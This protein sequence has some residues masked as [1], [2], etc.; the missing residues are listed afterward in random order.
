M[1]RGSDPALSN[2]ADSHREALAHGGAGD[3]FQPGGNLVCAGGVGEAEVVDVYA[4]T[5]VGVAG[6]LF[7]VDHVA[8]RTE[9]AVAVAVFDADGAFVHTVTHQRQGQHLAARAFDADGV[10]VLHTKLLGIFTVDQ[11]RVVGLD[12]TQARCLGT[13]A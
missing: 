10:A 4:G 13:T 1:Y 6:A 7:A 11:H 5:Q 9:F 8:G 3:V 2:G 12:H